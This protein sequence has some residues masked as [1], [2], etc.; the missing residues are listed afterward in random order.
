MARMSP[1]TNP[2]GSIPPILEA[3][4]REVNFTWL[5]KR[6]WS[7]D[8]I[9]FFS[10]HEP[11]STDSWEKEPISKRSS[12]AVPSSFFILKAQE[13]ALIAKVQIYQQSFRLGFV[14][15]WPKP[16]EC[17]DAIQLWLTYLFSVGGLDS[18]RIGEELYPC[19]PYEASPSKILCLKYESPDRYSPEEKSTCWLYREEFLAHPNIKRLRPKLLHLEHKASQL[20]KKAPCP[21]K[22]Q[23]KKLWAWPL[24]TKKPGRPGP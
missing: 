13:P 6:F 24:I 4:L 23:R 20:G 2:I 5:P 16:R 19:L 18:L 8:D 10:L 1:K 7:N 3:P 11:P 15:A 12:S 17:T 22:E 9:S 21:G 14:S